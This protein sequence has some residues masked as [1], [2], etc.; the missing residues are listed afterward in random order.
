MRASQPAFLLPS[1]AL[2]IVALLAG[3]PT[4]VCAP[5]A[6]QTCV[7]PGSAE[8]AQTCS[9]DGTA[10]GACDCGAGDDDDATDD[11]DGTDDD[12]A[13]DD[14]D[15]TDD[16]DD[17]TD[18]D[19]D[20]ATDDDDIAQETPPDLTGWWTVA[21]TAQG[22]YA[23]I[24]LST[25]IIEDDDDDDGGEEEPL[26]G[27]SVVEVDGTGADTANSTVTGGDGGW[28]LTVG[29]FNPAQ[30]RLTAPEMSDIS[31]VMSEAG[32]V[33]LADRPAL[34]MGEADHEAE[35]YEVVFGGAP[36]L[37]A[38]TVQVLLSV[39]EADGAGVGN[40][41]D[42]APSGLHGPISYISAETVISGNVVPEGSEQPQIGF[43]SVPAGVVQMT[44]TPLAGLECWG[45]SEIRVW[46]LTTTYVVVS[47]VEAGLLAA[48]PPSDGG[49]DDDSSNPGGDDDDSAR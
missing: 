41:V 49:D 8:G 14:D 47:C 19:D 17:G 3:C 40:A 46:P 7:C 6:A 34:L 28:E 18:D 12:D 22:V 37:S 43:G 4:Q 39:P 36:D 25:T 42:I 27:V 13:T 1:L 35:H 5:G 26:D 15:G 23:G 10:W 32:Y 48:G 33:L 11:D 21:P 31:M 2:A 38:G 16:D 30:V 20:D 44:Y 45:P 24:A 9:D 29:G